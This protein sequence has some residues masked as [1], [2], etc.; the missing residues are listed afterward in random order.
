ME[1]V[2]TKVK[3]TCQSTASVNFKKPVV[4]ANYRVASGVSG[5]PEFRSRKCLT[6]TAMQKEPINE[7]GLPAV[8]TNGLRFMDHVSSADH[9]KISNCIIEIER[10][11]KIIA[12]GRGPQNDLKWKLQNAMFFVVNATNTK[13]FSFNDNKDLLFTVLRDED[14]NGAAGVLN[15]GRRM[16]KVIQNI[17]PTDTHVNALWLLSRTWGQ[18]PLAPP[19]S[20]SESR[21]ILRGQ[22]AS[23]DEI[24]GRDSCREWTP[25]IKVY[26]TTKAKNIMAKVSGFLKSLVPSFDLG[27]NFAPATMAA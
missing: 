15:V 1:N 6:R 17:V 24:S 9:G 7:I 18:Y 21:G 13:L 2:E 25:R 22:I 11:K 27:L 10:K 14:I 19:I 16:P 8:E 3:E 20:L 26:Q 5:F 12:F 4:E 23:T